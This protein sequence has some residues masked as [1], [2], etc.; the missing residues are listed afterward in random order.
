MTRI[1]AWDF[2]GV[3]NRNIVDGRFIWADRFEADL[4]LPL[5]SFTDHIFRSGA[6]EEVLVGQVDLKDL[7]AEWLDGLGAAVAPQR[8]LDY[9]FE[10]DA[11]PDPQV[12][13]WV[14]RVT[15]RQ[16]VATNNE[17]YRT[18][19][20]W[21]EMGFSKHFDRLFAAGP[22]GAKKPQDAFFEQIEAWAG[23]DAS[24]LLVDDHL[25]NVTAARARGWQVFHFTDATRDDLP[26]VLG[27]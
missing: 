11:H 12:L 6:F 24:L 5:E 9:W 15:D 27:L 4:S 18:R 16:V 1:V 20:I 22:M 19:Y 8:V 3:L 2:D 7:V 13:E 25:P 21:N 17:A 14:G 23:S 26:G 10:H